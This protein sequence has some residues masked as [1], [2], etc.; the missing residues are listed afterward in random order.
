MRVLFG[1]LVLVAIVLLGG[2][3]AAAQGVSWGV[4]GGVNFA[5]L[6]V[7][8]GADAGVQVSDWRHRGRVLHLAD[9]L[10]PGRPA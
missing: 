2:A 5:T 7:D 9:G 8:R 1:S 6:S 3:Q 4:K 10:A